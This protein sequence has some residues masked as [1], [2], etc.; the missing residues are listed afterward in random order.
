MNCKDNRDFLNEIIYSENRFH[1]LAFA[2]IQHL[3]SLDYL[4]KN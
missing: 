3:A 1:R 2:K 4:A